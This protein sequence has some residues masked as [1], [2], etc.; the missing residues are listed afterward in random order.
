MLRPK[1]RKKDNFWQ[2]VRRY[3][4]G[5][6]AP[7]DPKEGQCLAKG[8]KVQWIQKSISRS[9]MLRP[10]TRKKDDF[11][12]KVR[13][14]SDGNVAQPHPKE[15]HFLA[16][17]PKVQ[18]IK[19]SATR[20]RT[21]KSTILIKKTRQIAKIDEK[22]ETVTEK[23]PIHGD[24]YRK[25]GDSYR[26]MKKNWRQLQKSY[27]LR[28]YLRIICIYNRVRCGTSKSHRSLRLFSR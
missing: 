17:G 9:E 12:Q 25:I 22:L 15:G 8:P 4:D 28:L 1:T 7:K 5:N 6:V 13:R 11:W 14:Y 2:K 16:K 23:C 24:S 3:S 19:K 26:K 21:P 27:T 10:K 20:S 18:W